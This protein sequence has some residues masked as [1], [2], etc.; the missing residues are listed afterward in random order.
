VNT[1]V[2]LIGLGAMGN[3]M[4]QSLLRAVYNVPA[5]DVRPEIA[6][7]FAKTAVWLGPHRSSWL[8]AT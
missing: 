5:F 2:R 6:Q 3:G 7:A 8:Q 1:N 4:A